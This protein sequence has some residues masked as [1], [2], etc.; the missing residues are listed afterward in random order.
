LMTL[1]GSHVDECETAFRVF[2]LAEVRR[3]LRDDDLER[4]PHMGFKEMTGKGRSVPAPEDGVDMQTRL[5]VGTYCDVTDKRGNFDLL[6]NRNGL[7]GLG[8]PIEIRQLAAAQ[9]ANGRDLRGA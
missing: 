1:L 9:G 2:L 6:A 4:R 5:V 8:L 7:I 3:R